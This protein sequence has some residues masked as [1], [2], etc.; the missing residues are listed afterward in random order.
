MYWLLI[1]ITNAILITELYLFAHTLL[2]GLK[3]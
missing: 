2:S 3:C 1:I